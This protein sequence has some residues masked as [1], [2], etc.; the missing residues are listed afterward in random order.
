MTVRAP[1]VSRLFALWLAVGSAAIAAGCRGSDSSAGVEEAAFVSRNR[2]VEPVASAALNRQFE[3]CCRRQFRPGGHRDECI[4]EAR[5]G[6]CRLDCRPPRDA[7]APDRDAGHDARFDAAPKNDA[8]SDTSALDASVAGSDAAPADAAPPF[9]HCPVIVSV[10]ATPSVANLFQT[11]TVS[12][13]ATDPDGDPLTLTWFPGVSIPNEG[14]NGPFLSPNTPEVGATAAFECIAPGS[15]GVQLFVDDGRGPVAIVNGCPQSFPVIAVTCGTTT[16]AGNACDDSTPCCGLTVCSAG[17]C[18]VC[19]NVG[20]TCDSTRPC[21]NGTQCTNG[22]CLLPVPTCMQDGAVCDA[23]HPCCSGAA[24]T[25]SICGNACGG[26]GAACDS[27]HPCCAD[28]ACTNGT[29][30]V[31]SCIPRDESCVS[32]GTACCNEPCFAGICH[33]PACPHTGQACNSTA[34]C[35]SGDICS[36]GACTRVLGCLLPGFTC[37]VPSDCCSGVCGSTCA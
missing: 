27:T 20:M 11:V 12:A 8:A 24:C 35:C 29:C 6:R 5:H 36:A 16:C 10:T 18:Q 14:V 33:E 17:A 30:Q 34:G 4:E 2:Q 9:D 21:C 28:D 25:N 13:V 15:I 19:V 31:T 22:L 37:T 32:G 26:T 7:G 23:T 3:E 1:D